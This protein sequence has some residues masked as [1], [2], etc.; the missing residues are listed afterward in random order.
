M[1]LPLE[2]ALNRAWDVEKGR[3]WW[4]SHLLALEMAVNVGFI[5]IVS[6]V[7]VGVNVAVV[8]IATNVRTTSTTNE[9]GDYSI[10]FLL[11][12]TYTVRVT[13]TQLGLRSQISNKAWLVATTDNKLV[14]TAV[15]GVALAVATTAQVT[16]SLTAEGLP[17]G[18]ADAIAQA[19]KSS[20]GTAI[21][22]LS[23]APATAPL[24]PALDQVMTQA[25]RNANQ[26]R[27]SGE[28]SSL[29][30]SINP[31]AE[32]IRRIS[33]NWTVNVV[34]HRHAR[35]GGSNPADQ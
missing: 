31:V 4:R 32:A 27:H 35:Q 9:T 5:V 28:A 1:F 30:R 34:D 17:Q 15:L 10:P 18:Q 7:L 25:L 22:Q 8:N 24:A 16:S 6:S 3:P 11:P 29:K 20:A 13:Q 21:P 23:Q 33:L 12:G 26:L 2:K 14:G 19:V